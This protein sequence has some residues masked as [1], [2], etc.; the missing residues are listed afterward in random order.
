MEQTY[1]KE[2]KYITIG[3]DEEKQ[4]VGEIAVTKTATFRELSRLDSRQTKLHW[5][6]ME[7]MEA[8]NVENDDDENG[9]MRVNSEALCDLIY[10]YIKTM[11]VTDED[12]TEQNKIEFL[13]DSGAIMQFGFWALSE[14]IAPFFSRLM[15]N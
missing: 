14:K 3:F 4:Q 7:T 6:I 15:S 13:K 5:K 11:L 10:K 8:S 12:F 1:Q 9:K 2:L